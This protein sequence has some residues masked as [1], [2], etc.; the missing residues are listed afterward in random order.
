M[1]SRGS[2]LFFLLLM[3][4]CSSIHNSSTSQQRFEYEQPQMGVPFRIVL[5]ALNENQAERAAKAAFA[6]IEDLNRK[7]SDYETDSEISELSR[8]SGQNKE[9]K[10]SD[11][12]W[13]VL[14]ASQELAE[15]SDGAFDVTIGPCIGLWRKARREKKLPPADQ[16]EHFRE[17]VGYR[18]LSLD[19]SHHTAKL[20]KPDMRLDVGGIAKG[21]AADEAIKTLRQFGIRSALVAASGDLSLGDPPPGEKGW[22][23][24]IAGYDRPNAPAAG[25][26]FLKNCG[27]STSGDLFQRVEID[28][29]RYSHILNPYTCVGMTNHALA[30]VIARTGTT[31]DSLA[32]AMTIMDPGAALALADDYNAGA[33]IIRLVKDIPEI[34]QNKRFPLPAK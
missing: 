6:R 4:G 18:F 11:D 28:G 1:K 9:V 12:L 30:T 16:V 21:F 15:K 29:V 31:A 3:V 20:A 13:N 25:Q 5:Y 22:K 26:V 34:Y 17:R 2:S 33:R 24:E 7:L 27:V 10:L 32:T 8:S 23:V 14:S 19:P